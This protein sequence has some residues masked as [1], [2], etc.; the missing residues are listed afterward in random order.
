[1]RKLYLAYG[2][3]LS[4]EQMAYRCPS[5]YPIGSAT[6]ND[7]QLLFKGS[8]SGSYLTVEPMKGGH[9]PLLVWSIDE[10]DERNL[11]RYEGYPSF[12]Y[13]KELPISLRSL[14]DGESLGNQH[15]LIYIMHE[16]RPLGCPSFGYYSI[17]NEGYQR[18]GF[19][20]AI[21]RQALV[22]SIG[23]RAAEKVLK[24]TDCDG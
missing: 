9:V 8:K 10:V 14:L 4:L 23:A 1:M 12:Y 17:C 18:F 24:G 21:L 3:N 19:D 16:A 5:A 13:K 22:D 7:Y 6:L 15:G 2:S 20:P 11:D